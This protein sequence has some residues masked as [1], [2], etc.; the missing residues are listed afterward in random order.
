MKLCLPE[1]FIKN[2]CK[3]HVISTAHDD[4]IRYFKIKF[5]KI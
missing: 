2:Y 5:N 4:F 3:V 1:A